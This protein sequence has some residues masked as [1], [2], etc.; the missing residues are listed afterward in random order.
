M[1]E[2]ELYQLTARSLEGVYDADTYRRAIRER[3]HFG[4]G[5]TQ[6]P[7]NVLDFPAPF[8]VEGIYAC[9]PPRAPTVGNAS[10]EELPTRKETY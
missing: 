7:E 10:I 5:L 2:T 8:S 1:S 6:H 4:D 9:I 3:E